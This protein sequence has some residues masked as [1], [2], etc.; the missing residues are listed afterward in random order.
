MRHGDGVAGLQPFLGV[1]SL[2]FGPL[3]RGWPFFLGRLSS[4]RLRLEEVQIRCGGLGLDGMLVPHYVFTPV[5]A[6]RVQSGEA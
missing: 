5:T 1:S 2:D 4:S 6:A 3:L